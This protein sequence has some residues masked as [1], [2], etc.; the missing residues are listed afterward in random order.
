MRVL[1]ELLLTQLAQA[2]SVVLKI[3]QALTRLGTEKPFVQ[4]DVSDLA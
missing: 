2:V 4:L 3:V 1:A